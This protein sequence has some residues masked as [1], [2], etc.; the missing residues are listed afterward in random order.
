[1]KT[2]GQSSGLLEVKTLNTENVRWSEKAVLPLRTIKASALLFF[3]V[4]EQV[5]FGRRQQ[6]REY[7]ADFFWPEH[8]RKAGLENLRQ[9]IYQLRKKLQKI[10]S[11]ALLEGDRRTVELIPQVSIWCDLGLIKRAETFDLLQLP[12]ERFEVLPNLVLYD[13]EPFEEW[14]TA[15]RG[16]VQRDSLQALSKAIDLEQVQGNWDLVEKLALR[17]LAQRES[18]EA[19]DYLILAKACLQQRKNIQAREWLQKT[20][21]TPSQI[22]QWLTEKG[23]GTAIGTADIRPIRLAVLPL[24]EIGAVSE[25]SFALGLLEDLIAQLS[26]FDRLEVTPSLSVLPFAEH[27]LAPRTIAKRLA[28]GRLLYGT[29]RVQGDQVKIA[30]QLLQPEPDRVL[31]AET[32]EGHIYELFN[33]QRKVVQ[34]TMEGLK[35]KLA[36][37]LQPTP[38]FIP[39]PKAYQLYLQG[40]SIFFRGNPEGTWAARHCFEQA[41]AIAPNY[42]RAYYALAS[43]IASLASWWGDQKIKDVADEYYAAIEKASE[44]ISLRFDVSASMAWVK[45]W[46]WNLPVAERYFRHAIIQP[47]ETSFCHSGFVHCLFTQGKLAEAY[48]AAQMGMEKNPHHVLNRSMLS[49]VSLLLGKYED[50]ERICR[51]ILLQMPEKHSTATMLIW[52]LILQGRPQEAVQAGEEHLQRTGQRLYFVVGRLAQAYL[53]AGD[54]ENAN[55][56]YLEMEER[57]AGGEKGFPYFMAIYQ[58]VAGHTERAL[59]LLEKH[60]PDRMTDY[61]WLKVQPEFK[62]LH[63][64]PR[65][66][67]I[68]GAVFGPRT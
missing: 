12:E 50:C 15:L 37:L 8:D 58:Q 5:Y 28:V 30:L 36:L 26:V 3:L 63:G 24:R 27:Q 68:L 57:S 66:E 14:L 65:F 35:E 40:W 11:D 34:K 55:R 46:E 54:Q 16:A 4:I 2:G 51:S 13:C 23:Q 45:M 19:R 29:L 53:A 1:M 47:T 18:P 39:A 43:T 61:L 60:L 20:E 7:L 67:T 10:A 32:F 21:L 44:D 6:R 9:T 59:E 33:I 38:V 49:D 62:P 56:L 41:I 31:W 48:E 42:H 25:K 52:V 64:H 17:Y 22:D